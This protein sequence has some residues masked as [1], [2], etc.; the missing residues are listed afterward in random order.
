MQI[1]LAGYNLDSAVMDEIREL[2][3]LP[4]SVPDDLPS[5]AKIIDSL[6]KEPL[7]PETI[8]AAYARIS[9]SPSS[10]SELRRDARSSVSRTR[11]S[12]ER[13]VFGLGHAS[14]AEHAVFN[15]D[16]TGISRL[17][18]EALEAHRLASYTE[19]SQ[20][21]IASSGDF[22]VPD[23]VREIGL[24]NRF[25]ESVHKLFA[26]Y[27]E[28]IT[29]LE[30]HYA[31]L[32]EHERNTKSREDSRYVLPLACR[33]QVG[34]TLNARGA[35]SV[36][37]ACNQAP[38]AEVKLIGKQMA[39]VLRHIG[40]S[41]IRY[42]EPN[43]K[44]SASES[45]LAQT[46]CQVASHAVPKF[47]DESAVELIDYPREGEILAVA[48]LLFSRG[49]DSFKNC[50]EHVRKMS[51]A[52]R[53]RIVIDSHNYLS[54][55]DPVRREL[56]LGTFVFSITLSASAFAQLKRHRM[57]TIIA[58]H[59]QPELGVT[60]PPILQEV[61]GLNI[62]NECLKTSEELY[63]ALVKS[64]HSNVKSAA[65][66]ALT[67]AHR[68]RVVFQ[69]NSRELTH[70]SR[71][72]EDAYAQWDIRATAQDMIRLARE[73]CPGLMLLAAG[74]DAFPDLHARLFPGEYLPT[75]EGKA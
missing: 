23:E 55:H 39:D 36:I 72:R 14:V 44:W 6:A 71:L 61:G 42:I 3:D 9:R 31:D 26:G 47:R 38:L 67:N 29:L 52:E 16:I 64:L 24:T 12:N 25:T 70:L 35:E 63:R 21:Y 75:A 40:P 53:C 48:G 27:R 7:T 74:K 1:T 30:K 68:R 41:L 73:A 18:L 33:S 5:L 20:R 66:Y 34:I 28:L 17:A 32:P 4:R 45:A 10:V 37:H 51:D 11:Q 46:A 60:T 49:S 43:P 22:E 19:G 59:Y 13:I 62:F 56:E 15:L 2:T 54:V 8:S 58:Q 65:Q 69:A 50:L 57:A